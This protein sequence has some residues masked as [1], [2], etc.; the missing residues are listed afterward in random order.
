M[1]HINFR[2]VTDILEGQRH[3]SEMVCS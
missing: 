1:K 3:N 2:V